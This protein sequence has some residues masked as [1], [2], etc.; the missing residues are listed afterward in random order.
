M[1]NRNY[2]KHYRCRGRHYKANRL[3]QNL[4][5]MVKLDTNIAM[6]YDERFLH[7]EGFSS[8]CLK[9]WIS[10]GGNAGPHVR[11]AVMVTILALHTVCLMLKATSRRYIDMSSD[12][13]D[14][15]YERD[16]LKM[17]LSD[18][19]AQVDLLT[20]ELMANERRTSQ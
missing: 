20:R 9:R 1:A 6:A 12:L 14:I 16:A 8:D 13:A 15:I 17:R 2:I 19:E 18:A 4:P 7:L 10:K 11:V 3:P 5:A